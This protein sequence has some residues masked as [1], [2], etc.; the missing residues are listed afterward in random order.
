MNIHNVLKTIYINNGD[1]EFLRYEIIGNSESEVSF[2]MAFAEV[3]IICNGIEYSV[4]SKADNITLDHLVPPRSGFQ[5]SV[6]TESYPGKSVGT[7]IEECK[8]HRAS[9][10]K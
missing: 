1:D 7:A 2:A 4:W 9:W 6:R 3:R 10:G 8:K 5:Q